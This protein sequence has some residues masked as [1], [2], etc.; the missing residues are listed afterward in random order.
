MCQF[1]EEAEHSMENA[2]ETN[3]SDK[4]L[5][6]NSYGN[7]KYRKHEEIWVMQEHPYLSSHGKL[8]FLQKNEHSRH[9]KQGSH[10]F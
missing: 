7:N 5:K 8:G 2:M 10:K 6:N 1:G 4:Y 3:K 9:F